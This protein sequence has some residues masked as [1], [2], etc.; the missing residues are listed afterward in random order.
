[1]GSFLTCLIVGAILV[2]L[3]ILNMK[4]NISSL[5]SYHR[6]RV[7]EEDR[8]P[9]GRMVGLGT[10]LCGI[11]VVMFGTLMLV[12]EKTQIEVFSLVGTVLLIAGLA[13]GLI[14]MFR[15]MIKYNG[16]IF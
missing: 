2:V 10:V 4:G 11:G 12:Y 7:R 3:G 15:A 9:F 13:V 6:H 16:G 8:L 1:M 5:H 14:L